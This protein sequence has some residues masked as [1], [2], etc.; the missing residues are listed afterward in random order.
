MM[1][2]RR[3]ITE[4]DARNP[5]RRALAERVAINSVV[6]GSAADLIKI[7]M[8]DLHKDITTAEKDSPLFCTKMILQIHDELVF[9]VPDANTDAVLPLVTAR[10][11]D[12]MDLKVPLKVDA[13]VSKDWFG[14]K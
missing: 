7:A 1:G 9:E 3:P 2:R 4:I 8:I 14:G 11:E 10:M 5:Q 6:Q 13:Q 12:A